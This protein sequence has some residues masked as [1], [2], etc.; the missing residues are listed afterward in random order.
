M[1]EMNEWMNERN[2][3]KAREK[4]FIRQTR[5]QSGH[6]VDEHRPADRQTDLQSHIHTGILFTHIL[7]SC[8]V[9]WTW[10]NPRNSRHPWNKKR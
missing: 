2:W 10:A 4:I 6:I 9:L 8:Q 1:T 3:V 5:H 7:D